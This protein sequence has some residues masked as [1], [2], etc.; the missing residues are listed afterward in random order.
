MITLYT[1]LFSPFIYGLQSYEKNANKGK[2]FGEKRING[3]QN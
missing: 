2:S 1:I 3:V